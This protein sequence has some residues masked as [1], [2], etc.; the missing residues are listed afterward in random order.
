M[1]QV[2]ATDAINATFINPPFMRRFS[3]ESRSPSVTK[4]NT[5]YYPHFLC[6]AAAAASTVEGV[7]IDVI[8]GS[9]GELTFEEVVERTRKNDARLVVLDTSTP[10]IY[11]DLIYRFIYDLPV[12]N[13]I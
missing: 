5:L 2:A 13:V 4:S 11:S 9:P 7:T 1:I 8:D 10:C 6:Y 3:R 12:L